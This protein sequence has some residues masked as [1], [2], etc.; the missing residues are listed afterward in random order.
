MAV[1]YKKSNDFRFINTWTQLKDVVSQKSLY[2]DADYQGLTAAQ[3][4]QYLLQLYQN[5]DALAER[6]GDEYYSEYG[7]T[8]TRYA[9]IVA[10]GSLIDYD[11]VSNT[12]EG[13]EFLANKFNEQFNANMAG[14]ANQEWVKDIVESK[15]SGNYEQF[16][17][18]Y[19]KDDG[20]KNLVLEQ[21]PSASAVTEDM[22]NE[23][24]SQLSSVYTEQKSS[25]DKQ[26]LTAYENTKVYVNE[27]LQANARQ[28][29]Y[30]NATWW[31]KTLNTLWQMP[32]AWI[33]EL[34]NIVEGIIDLFAGL[35]AFDDDIRAFVEKDII[36]IDTAVLNATDK[37]WLSPYAEDNA[38]KFI[39]QIGVNIVDMLP[40]AIPGVGQA[41][42]Y[43][44]SAGRT[45]EGEL[46]SGYSYGEAITYTVASTAIE[47][48]TESISG[49]PFFNKGKSIT[50]KWLSG[51]K[52]SNW[53]KAH[54]SWG[55][56]IIRQ[57]LG[58]GLEEV[59]AGVGSGI[60]HGVI[61]GDYQLEGEDLWN[62]FLIGGLVG[63]IMAGGN[64][65]YRHSIVNRTK[66]K[67]SSK[68]ASIKLSVG[69]AQV[70]SEYVKT[71]AKKLDAGAKLSKRNQARFDILKNIKINALLD[72]DGQELNGSEAQTILDF[73]QE[74]NKAKY[75]RVGTEAGY[76]DKLNPKKNVTTFEEAER[77]VA[78]KAKK[79]A[80][81][82]DNI[83]TETDSTPTENT[84]K[85]AYDLT[86]EEDIAK[87]QKEFIT[88][89]AM[90]LGKMMR[91]FGEDSVLK[92]IEGYTKWADKTIDDVIALLTLGDD[93]SE[94]VVSDNT[95]ALKEL[96][97]AF[98]DAD[99][100]IVNS[101]KA[102][103]IRAKIDGITETVKSIKQNSKVFTTGNV[104]LF[105]TTDAN[106]STT[107]FVGKNL[108][109]NANWLAAR[110]IGFAKD[111]VALKL[112][113][114]NARLS[115]QRVATKKLFTEIISKLNLK[116]RSTDIIEQDLAIVLLYTKNN[117]LMQQLLAMTDSKTDRTM[118]INYFSDLRRTYAGMPVQ[119]A[120]GAA[121]TNIASCLNTM[122]DLENNEDDFSEAL[123]QDLQP[124]EIIA[125]YLNHE[126][127]SFPGITANNGLP[128][129]AAKLNT[130]YLHFKNKFGFNKELDLRQNIDWL[131]E[132]SNASN[133]TADGY[134]VLISELEKFQP[135]ISG[136]GFELGT[137]N[138]K[139]S[140]NELLNYYLDQF[141]GL[142]ITHKGL[143]SSDD[144]ITKVLDVSAINSKIASLNENSL[145]REHIGT[146][147]QFIQSDM[148]NKFK[149]EMLNAKI[150]VY[151]DSRSSTTA[152]ASGTPNQ[153][154][155]IFLNIPH[156]KEGKNRI[157][158]I[159]GVGI[160]LDPD[161]GL[162][163]ETNG[164][165]KIEDKRHAVSEAASAMIHEMGHAISM[166]LDLQGTFSD[167]HIVDTWVKRM[168]ALSVI[169]RT[170]LSADIIDWLFG[171][172]IS[173]LRK[174]RAKF[175]LRVKNPNTGTFFTREQFE[176]NDPMIQ[177]AL[178]S[179]R[180]SFL[181]VM[182]ASV[183]DAS[184]AETIF[185]PLA[186]YLYWSG[187][188]HEM[189]A[190]GKAS[191][192]ARED[193][194]QSTIKSNNKSDTI[195]LYLSDEF[196]KTAPKF[197][198]LL[199]GQRAAKGRFFL[200]NEIE[201]IM[202]SPEGITQ[203]IYSKIQN[204]EQLK[205]EFGVE[206]DSDLINPD[207][208]RGRLNQAKVESPQSLFISRESLINDI[209]DMY[210]CTY[211]NDKFVSGF[212]SN[213][214]RFA[215]SSPTSD[216]YNVV[217]YNDGST[218]NTGDA[219]AYTNESDI[220]AMASYSPAKGKRPAGVTVRLTTADLTSLVKQQLDSIVKL[221]PDKRRRRFIADGRTFVTPKA[222][223]AYLTTA[224][225]VT[226][227]PQFEVL[228]DTISKRAITTGRQK[229]Y[230][231]D[232]IYITTDGKIYNT[233]ATMKTWAN[234]A[235]SKNIANLVG[236]DIADNPEKITYKLAALL[237]EKRIVRL[238]REG[239]KWK[240]YG[241]PNKLQDVLIRELNAERMTAP[242]HIEIPSNQRLFFN[243]KGDQH[244]E[245]H[246]GAWSDPNFIEVEWKGDQWYESIRQIMTKYNI[247]S[248]NGF[249]RLGFSN[250]FIN[251]LR[252]VGGTEYTQKTTG[253]KYIS[254]GGIN[255]QYILEYL[256]DSSNT[257][258]SRNI[259]IENTPIT[260]RD[261]KG[262]D[263]KQNA[264]IRTIEDAE[265]Y[266]SNLRSS[267]LLLKGT[268]MIY[269]SWADFEKAVS[270]S[271]NDPAIVE[272]NARN[273]EK[274]AKAEAILGRGEL[275]IRLLNADSGFD[276]RGLDI[277]ND[278]FA[279]A[280][281]RLF[282]GVDFK[283]SRETDLVYT[284]SD[285]KES[286][287]IK[288]AAPNPEELLLHKDKVDP[289][290]M[291]FIKD[292]LETRD[293]TDAQQRDADLDALM[294]ATH[295]P[296]YGDIDLS[297]IRNI[298]AKERT[299]TKASIER[300][301]QLD[302]NFAR[303]EAY[304]QLNEGSPEQ[305][306]ERRNIIRYYESLGNFRTRLIAAEDT[307]YYDSLLDSVSKI[308]GYMKRMNQNFA[309]AYA[310][311]NEK[312]GNWSPEIKAAL[313]NQL[314][315]LKNYREVFIRGFEDIPPIHM[316]Y[317]GYYEHYELL[318][319]LLRNWVAGHNSVTQD[320]LA[321]DENGKSIQNKLFEEP[322]S[323]V[324]VQTDIIN[325]IN[326][327]ASDT[328]FRESIRTKEKV[329]S[330][331][332]IKSSRRARYS[333]E[334]LAMF[335]DIPTDLAA[336]NTFPKEAQQQ[337]NQ[338]ANDIEMLA[339]LLNNPDFVTDV[340]KFYGNDYI[341]H[342]Q[343]LYNQSVAPEPGNFQS[344]SKKDM[345]AKYMVQSAKSLG[346]SD[347]EI[348]KIGNDIAKRMG[349][350]ATHSQAKVEA[351]KIRAER[352]INYSQYSANY[353]LRLR[354]VLS[355]GNPITDAERSE[356]LKRTSKYIFGYLWRK[357]NGDT[358][359]IFNLSRD[360]R[361]KVVTALVDAYYSFLENPK[362]DLSAL[363]FENDVD[364][365]LSEMKL[366]RV[367]PGDTK[368]NLVS[369]GK[370]KTNLNID[371]E[372]INNHLAPIIN[373]E[374]KE[375][376]TK[377]IQQVELFRNTVLSED[378]MLEE[379][380][381]ERDTL[382]DKL[383]RESSR[384]DRI[385]RSNVTVISSGAYIDFNEK[386]G[387]FEDLNGNEIASDKVDIR[388]LTQSAYEKYLNY[389]IDKF[390][391]N[392][393]LEISEA[394]NILD[395]ITRRIKFYADKLPKTNKY[396]KPST[397]TEAN[398]N[399]PDESDFESDEPNESDF[400]PESKLLEDPGNF[401]AI[402]TGDTKISNEVKSKG[403]WADTVPKP[404]P[405]R[406]QL[407][408]NTNKILSYVYR[409]KTDTGSFIVSSKDFLED[410][411]SYINEF[412]DNIYDM[413]AFIEWVESSPSVPIDSPA[414]ANIFALINQVANS[415][416]A[417]ESLQDRA[418]NLII[419][420]GSRAGRQLG[421]LKAFGLTPVDQLVG[422][423]S[424]FMKL[425]NDERR[426]LARAAKMQTNAIKVRDYRAAEIAMDKV[427]AI[428]K[429]HESEL[430]TSCNI[431]AKG[432]TPEERSTRMHNIVEKVTSWRYFAMLGAPSTFFTKNITSNVIITGM[433]KV[434]E[435]IAS[436]LP[437]G[438]YFTTNYSFSDTAFDP[439]FGLSKEQQ[440]RIYREEYDKLVTAR[441]AD[442]KSMVLEPK[443]LEDLET[444]AR[445]NAVQRENEMRKDLVELTIEQVTQ[446]VKKTVTNSTDYSKINIAGFT[447]YLNNFIETRYKVD[448]K[449]PT[450]SKL[451]AHANEYLRKKFGQYKIDT[452]VQEGHKTVVKQLLE[453][454]GL[455]DAIMNNSV[456]KYNRGYD[457][458]IGALQ[459]ITLN[460]EGKLD[461]ISE[462]EASIL[463]DAINKN[464]PFKWE[465][466]NKYY[467]FIFKTMDWG[468][469]KFIKPKIIATVEK[470]VASNMNN[471]EI[472]DLLAGKTAMRA[473]FEEF[474]A[475]A[476][477]DAM[478]TYFREDTD[479]YK[480]LMGLFPK[481]PVAQL[482][483]GTIVP[484]PRMMINTMNTALSYSPVGFIKAFLIAR[485]D[486]TAFAKLKINKELG[487]AITGSSLITMGAIL[488]A[489]GLIDFDDDDKYGG[490][491]IIIGQKIRI[492][493]G[494]LSP[495]AIP[496]IIGATITHG[497]TE[498]FWNAAT[499][500]ANALLDAT[501]LGEVIEIFGGNQSASDF[502]AN[503]FTSYIN[504]FI[505][506]IFRHVARS[507][508]P[509]KKDYSSNK[510][511]KVFQRTAAAIPGL[512]LLVPDKIDPYTGDAV[513]QNADAS[514]GW[515][516][517]L[518]F[519]NA[520]S[521]AKI[522][523]NIESP[524]EIESKAVGAAT[525]GPAKTYKINGIEYT[526][527]DELYREY[528]ILRAKLY[529]QYA[530]SIINTTSY[531][532]MTLEKKRS[533]LKQLQTK[534]TEEARK[535]LNIGK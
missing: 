98:G 353:A 120:A 16:I 117:P 510:A 144:F 501:I 42:Y 5:N 56:E 410:N 77:E 277:S 475:Y 25:F 337:Y 45:L 257:S 118:L 513:Y 21:I 392:G 248:F 509:S 391:E 159:G 443:E 419:R 37:S 228:F 135:V 229:V 533:K 525:T 526:I 411:A 313:D 449:M 142:M 429:K 404:E 128:V 532:N 196:K 394:G 91:M 145:T 356:L 237:D 430:P 78:E 197:I 393:Q 20:Y 253:K 186:E 534:A 288:D 379:F 85:Q 92:G 528:Q 12:T 287:K 326:K 407:S 80:I 303:I 193:L 167:T 426:L 111:V 342:L 211:E 507:I 182:Q 58:E 246:A 445:Y 103:A 467:R 87:A 281:S 194:I 68:N 154:L 82:D 152:V 213:I 311:Y 278:A 183:F 330:Y 201:K 168:S 265:T 256:R 162:P 329:A 274:I 390:L 61:T 465:L 360:Q 453:N 31:E 65:V 244:V 484:F 468:D 110:D 185:R 216:D 439:I 364:V 141:C 238:Y 505:P 346:R 344:E 434:S 169:D 136:T 76:Y 489:C 192:F 333:K 276:G 64:T 464:A 57:A 81:P 11:K 527:P 371:R 112:L 247:N 503:S 221:V 341:Y 494:D 226:S 75:Y 107:F 202:N 150:Y 331:A 74:A 129:E 535:Q 514:K 140:F 425:D 499:D 34:G 461:D 367:I 335:R 18:D 130:M 307:Q 451:V 388:R 59:V 492:A 69:K 480:K 249:K 518:S 187:F 521:P 395:S 306:A 375:V 125:E 170:S 406:S 373:G 496:L 440:R 292:I 102:T 424:R 155:A 403:S 26:A 121:L 504:Q 146:I 515:A 495:S 100:V 235:E 47:I 171:D 273:N 268:D 219:D 456:S 174:E 422:F 524:I 32:A 399:V 511:I 208:W 448:G 17:L 116:N 381:E 432:L 161:T 153:G 317:P 290:I 473:K 463:A 323:F 73:V 405:Y 24:M 516:H 351:K 310:A 212:V 354:D 19:S 458:K 240:A 459:E 230:S 49:S 189:Y 245:I 72:G 384:R 441:S 181:S 134:N 241:L 243:S 357:K 217:F 320:Y 148:K 446:L 368:R 115:L 40:L 215:E 15:Y 444:E 508:D 156:L 178:L 316:E 214:K 255:R 222:A 359:D 63:G 389:Q 345:W 488:A 370:P 4:E 126:F 452:A 66:I 147:G 272:D 236:N 39:H 457:V 44:S 400:I 291:G 280:A 62:S 304:E 54:K 250:D 343:R 416:N 377:L 293:V 67:L 530:Q 455:L 190:N 132:F 149:P 218:K 350:A 483:L 38:A 309:K 33:G 315:K 491:Q 7:D 209:E 328:E 339:T 234:I 259:L 423:I 397:N 55:T 409:N 520:L 319:N 175:S 385:S 485:N 104:T 334:D 93:T 164:K 252:S 23:T 369:V 474:V 233:A 43:A 325:Y 198:K 408:K 262:G 466:L 358:V 205:E 383:R 282:M 133:Y 206:L 94:L 86:S 415:V 131:S 297:V 531:Q 300:R 398:S 387:S 421:M 36:A 302:K 137:I 10:T 478:K 232:T 29:V 529:S 279:I 327:W 239:E 498:G 437:K 417:P 99:F 519:F 184:A 435:L 301:K 266:L 2:N 53:Y 428:V 106:V 412:T 51:T 13:Q 418:R 22:F 180:K 487:K 427:L 46:Q 289:R 210:D 163:I 35:G 8:Q 173:E 497:A 493:L 314:E 200:Q 41:I 477:N 321:K 270:R 442:G 271:R 1:T 225:T 9:M 299:G 349:K 482:I 372:Y 433:D 284:D 123:Q 523:A 402:N 177:Q 324:A 160:V 157:K 472:Q 378:A 119:K 127:R 476:T 124:D 122:L 481:N 260:T 143:I 338:L 96:K 382:L 502:V 431:F 363:K 109:V 512:S 285:G 263:W 522:T 362:T 101:K 450:S 479:F 151:A 471:S 269:E 348:K 322:K 264:H 506:S 50:G 199:D 60:M 114:Q 460:A 90:T 469:K 108:Y 254:M 227:N 231:G 308:G 88:N 48:G 71:T 295:Y 396:Y 386:T 165:Y 179:W 332:Q 139:K 470:L 454:S 517:I 52:I 296:A 414:E 286:E 203:R 83:F 436:K 251:R 113:A 352:L 361:Y 158:S 376:D 336:L 97:S 79:A 275:L 3:K 191:A 500:G 207:F 401:I 380:V 420:L 347:E 365:A 258:L 340:S 138:T 28:E 172:N 188:A 462:R 176:N 261:N 89:G 27:K 305:L 242:S 447:K 95:T 195:V 204:I 413:T 105:A 486:S 312:S 6:M 223:L 294:Q 283:N 438:K 318:Y 490:A 355:S 70:I 14:E 166:F 374:I 366:N 267:A 220:I 298:I 30:D 224:P 84:I